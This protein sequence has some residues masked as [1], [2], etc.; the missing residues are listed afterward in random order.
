MALSPGDYT[1]DILDTNENQLLVRAFNDREFYSTT[2]L[3]DQNWLWQ[4][5]DLADGSRFVP[6]SADIE[7]SYLRFGTQTISNMRESEQHYGG[8]MGCN[9]MGGTYFANAEQ[10]LLLAGP[11][12]EAMGCQEEAMASDDFWFER[13]TS[14]Y[15]YTIDRDTLR[16]FAASGDTFVFERE[17]EISAENRIYRDILSEW[18]NDAPILVVT[19]SAAGR[20]STT[21]DDIR[22]TLNELFGNGHNDMQAETVDDL[23]ARNDAPTALADV[24]T[25]DATI[26][27]DPSELDDLFAN[28]TEAGWET[29]A[30]QYNSAQ[31]IF[32]FSLLRFNVAGDQAIVYYGIRYPGFNGGYY[33]LT[34][35][36]GDHWIGGSASNAW[37]E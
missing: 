25:L 32:T 19:K 3:I 22:A 23:L 1:L 5:T 18:S 21:P 7:P 33:A 35:N 11:D 29:I 37:S 26:V 31:T 24:L 36:S 14:I 15:R 6:V 13:V 28:G 17:V 10:Q 8:N 34:S 30:D 9:G 12:S 16:L 2:D 20:P 4:H 27:V